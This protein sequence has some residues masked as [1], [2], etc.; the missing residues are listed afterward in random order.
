MK[1]TG[2]QLD[3]AWEDPEANFR[4]G[5]E[6][7]REAA[8]AGSA[9]VVFP[10]MFATG[11]SMNAHLV[12]GFAEETREFLSRLA[13]ELGVHILGGFA[14]P[15]D[16]RPANAC[17]LHDPSGEEILHYRKIHPFTLAGEA[18]AFVAGGAVNTAEVQGVRVTPLICYDLRFPE[19]FRS[20]ATSTDLFCVLANWPHPRRHHWSL[21]LQA[22]AVENQAYVLGVNRSGSG[23]GHHYTGDSA[24]LDPMG[25]VLDQAEAGAE[26]LVQGHVD[27]AEVRRVR[28]HFRFLEDRRPELYHRLER[29]D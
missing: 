24:L 11:F 28:D 26:V 27:P 16:P 4:R 10:E 9:L 8:E 7:A 21:L 6:L 23:D 17:S 19:P 12:A 2:V 18:E 25:T 14:E 20:A 22:R 15:A 1:V 13:R 3:I 29:E 5:E